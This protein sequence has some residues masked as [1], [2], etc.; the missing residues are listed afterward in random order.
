MMMVMTMAAINRD[1]QYLIM[2]VFL[3]S[4]TPSHPRS[5]LPRRCVIMMK[6]HDYDDSQCVMV[7]KIHDYDD[8]RCVMLMKIHDYDDDQCMMMMKINDSDDGQCVVMM[9]IH[10]HGDRQCVMMIMMMLMVRL[11]EQIVTLI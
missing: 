8:G 10:D 4:L 2:Q 6:I 9:K 1:D 5:S 7:I 11:Q 3:S